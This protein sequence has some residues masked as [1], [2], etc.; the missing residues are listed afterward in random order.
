MQV[1]PRPCFALLLQVL[2]PP[3]PSTPALDASL[4]WLWGQRSGKGGPGAQGGILMDTGTQRRAL[5]AHPASLP[6]SRVPG[7]GHRG[8]PGAVV[9]APA[10]GGLACAAGAASGEGVSG[11][12]G[13]GSPGLPTL[14]APPSPCRTL[15]LPTHAV[16]YSGWNVG[17][18]GGGSGWAGSSRKGVP[19]G[20][21][22]S[23]FAP[24]RLPGEHPCWGDSHEYR[25]C[26]LPVSSTCLLD[27]CFHPLRAPPKSVPAFYFILLV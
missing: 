8:G 22:G 7:S 27:S 18:A 17:G 6:P 5:Q 23:N 12:G 2:P 21:A 11:G 1:Q 10:G 15:S 19:W 25:L 16:P 14:P 26:S 9:P 24:S 20:P 13:K 4:L 3:G